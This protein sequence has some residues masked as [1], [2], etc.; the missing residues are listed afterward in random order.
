LEEFKLEV[1]Y[2]GVVKNRKVYILVFLIMSN[3]TYYKPLGN[4]PGNSSPADMYAV[5]N[6]ITAYAQSAMKRPFERMHDLGGDTLKF[7]NQM[8]F[9]PAMQKFYAVK[10]QLV[11]GAINVSNRL[12]QNNLDTMVNNYYR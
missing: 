1:C 7:Y 6:Y 10:N 8:Y 3:M 4:V 2:F 5:F 12:K 9:Q 11:N